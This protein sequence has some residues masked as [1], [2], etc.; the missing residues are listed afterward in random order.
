MEDVKELYAQ[1]GWKINT[2][3]SNFNKD[4]CDHVC[5]TIGSVTSTEGRY[6]AWWM[7]SSDD[8]FKVSS[9]LELC[10]SREEY[11]EDISKI[12]EKGFP[13]KDYHSKLISFNRLWMNGGKLM[14]VG[15]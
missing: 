10:R 11:I 13:F 9:A 4:I 1:D 7:P 5:N 14:K 8:K 2:L 6:K 12:W 3:D 15:N